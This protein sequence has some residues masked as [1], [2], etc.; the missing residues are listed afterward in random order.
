MD[1]KQ[2]VENERIKYN[3]KGLIM[4]I[5]CD[6]YKEIF[7]SGNSMSSV[8]TNENMHYRIGGQSIP[9]L[10]TLFLILVDKGY[11]SLTETIETYLP[12]VPNCDKIELQML[13]NMTSGLPDVILDPIVNSNTD[14]FKQ[15]TNKELLNI[16]YNMKQLFPP[17]EKFYFGHVTN[18]LLLCSVI[19]IKMKTSIKKLIKKYIFD[20]LN[21]KD[22]YYSSK[23]VIQ[24]PVFHSFT[25]YRIPC[26]EDSTYWNGS[27]GAYTTNMS[28]TASDVNILAKNIGNG[29]LI[30]KKLYNIQMCNMLNN[31]SLYYGMGLAVGGFGLD[32]LKSEDYPH[33]IIW[34]DQNYLGYLGIWAFIPAFDITINIQTNTDN[35]DNFSIKYILQNFI[36]SDIFKNKKID[37]S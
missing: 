3:L 21:L 36:D 37:H 31:D 17:G 22:T 23:Q 25:N 18:I 29:K 4:C 33:T 12:N 35:C 9:I 28:S 14:M 2:F 26:Y 13:C 19:K 7:V 15:W 24:H 6:N 5:S 10:T 11:L 30:S 8:P 34:T 27:W 16:I 1:I 20:V 32:Y